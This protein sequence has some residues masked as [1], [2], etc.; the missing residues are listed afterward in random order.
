[1][2]KQNSHPYY[3]KQEKKLS[4]LSFSAFAEELD[5]VFRLAVQKAADVVFE[6]LISHPLSFISEKE[7]AKRAGVSVRTASQ[8]IRLMKKASL[9]I[10]CRRYMTSNL[11]KVGSY[12]RFYAKESL[13]HIFPALAKKTA[14]YFKF[15]LI[16][17]SIITHINVIH[18]PN[19]YKTVRS[20]TS[21]ELLRSNADPPPRIL[22]PFI[23]QG[24]KNN[25]PLYKQAIERNQKLDNSMSYE[26]AKEKL[27]RY[28][29]ML[30][31]AQNENEFPDAAQQRAIDVYQREINKWQQRVY[32]L[33]P[34]TVS[35]LESPKE[36]VNL[37]K[38]ERKSESQDNPYKYDKWF[39]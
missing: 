18:S 1:M 3:K 33:N 6:S 29:Q 24:A 38:E 7:I 21:E 22:V 27:R 37:P 32:N 26:E 11:Y 12:F 17:T 28:S 2:L 14:Y 8:A 15:G 25:V 16:S 30:Y 35:S 39:D 10:S 36:V 19:I 31:A 5:E 9:L 20:V 23:P 4:L 34:L 13:A